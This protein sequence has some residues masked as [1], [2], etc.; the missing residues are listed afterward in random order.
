[1]KYLSYRRYL[2][3]VIT[4]AKKNFYGRRFENVLGDMKKTWSLI[5]EIRG[6]TKQ[7]LK[8]S[9][10]IDNQLLNDTR[11][12]SNKFNE[13]F[14][15]V[16]KKLNTKIYSSTLYDNNNDGNFTSYL[17]NRVNNSIYNIHI[18]NIL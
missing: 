15:S 3:K 9:F 18:S 4:L 6:K 17:K 16:A 14:A 8:P 10:I 1:M 13:F 11:K 12:I 2:K 7:N 5:N